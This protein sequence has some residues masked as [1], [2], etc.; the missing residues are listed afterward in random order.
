MEVVELEKLFLVDEVI[1]VE[2][3]QQVAQAVGS[4]MQLIHLFDQAEQLRLCG[5][6]GVDLRGKLFE[7]LGGLGVDA[8]HQRVGV[9]GREFVV[10]LSGH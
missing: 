3:D 7:K 6:V 5:D 4:A 10:Q 9:F 8:G 1:A 2:A